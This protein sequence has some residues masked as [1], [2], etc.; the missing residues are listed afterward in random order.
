MKHER[1]PFFLS[2]NKH[3][4]FKQ[5]HFIKKL[6]V[7]TTLDFDLDFEVTLKDH[8]RAMQNKNSKGREE[9]AFG[10]R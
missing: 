2:S 4:Y 8:P 3:I 10:R 6:I 9:R 7:K 5:K 1:K